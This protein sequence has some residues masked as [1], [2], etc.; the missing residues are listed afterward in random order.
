[1]RFRPIERIHSEARSCWT[2]SS[3]PRGWGSSPLRSLTR[4]S[5][6]VSEEKAMTLDYTLGAIVTA[7]IF[8]Y[9]VYALIRPER[10]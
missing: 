6:N 2:S 10:F 5:V 1:M 3:S 8:V 4:I 9:L 7:G